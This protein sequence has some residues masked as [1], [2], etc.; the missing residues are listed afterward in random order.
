MVLFALLTPSFRRLLWQPG[1]YLAA[2]VG[3]VLF[4][5]VVWWN[6]IH[7]WASF[8][9]QGGRIGGGGSPLIHGGPLVWLLGSLLFLT[10][11]MWFWLSFELGQSLFRFRSLPA[12]QRLMVCLAVVPLGFFLA[13]SFTTGKVL[14]HWSL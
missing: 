1:P 3:F 9:F 13:T 11:W 12:P 7:D 2:I 8:K 5:P 10:P 4:S 14:P 6:A